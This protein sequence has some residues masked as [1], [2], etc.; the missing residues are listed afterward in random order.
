MGGNIHAVSGGVHPS[1][2]QLINRLAS[3]SESKPEKTIQRE[4]NIETASDENRTQRLLIECCPL[5]VA[6]D[7]STTRLEFYGTVLSC[8]G[9]QET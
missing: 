2:F 5:P 3:A 7:L 4:K 6:G 1:Y 8:E 9:I